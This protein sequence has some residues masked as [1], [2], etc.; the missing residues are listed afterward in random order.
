MPF[1]YSNWIISTLI[2][3]AETFFGCFLSC[4]LIFCYQPESVVNCFYMDKVFLFFGIF[5]YAVI[6]TPTSKK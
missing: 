5:S 6:S 4:G 3:S 2:Q 1:N